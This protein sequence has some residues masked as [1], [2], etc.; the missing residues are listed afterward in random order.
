M[1]I[2]AIALPEDQGTRFSELVNAAHALARL[3][4][5]VVH[6]LVCA[7][8]IDD[9][10]IR[11]AGAGRAYRVDEG[12][13]EYDCVPRALL[14][15]ASV[16]QQGLPSVVLCMGGVMG[17][18]L[19]PRLATRLHV[20]YVSDCCAFE[21]ES[22]PDT[23]VA[24]VRPIYGGRAMEVL[25]S[26]GA[27]TVVG[28]RPKS[29]LDGGERPL[30]QAAVVE[31]IE[32]LADAPAL[33]MGRVAR[34]ESGLRAGPALDEAQVVVSGGR[35]LGSADG[36]AD[37]RQLAS[38]LGGAVGASRAAVD[39]GW[40]DAGAQVGQTGTTVAPNLYVAIG[41]SGAVQHVAGM[42]AAR[43]IVAINS[44]DEAPIFAIAD[45]GVVADYREILPALLQ[46][47][48]A[49]KRVER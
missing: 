40:I 12:T 33:A 15:A 19:A 35:G 23:G 49:D 1:T 31:A 39:A 34:E 29:F 18:E 7:G 46:E 27:C 44:D 5:D 13:T 45:V 26:T 37:L 42:G 43:H 48:G 8:V 2:L 17:R 6:L 21:A 25:E 38:V 9:G 16:C 47:L 11:A 4:A 3:R 24:F 22:V 20:P 36:F 41:I 30:G 28:I 32:L 10:M 14:A